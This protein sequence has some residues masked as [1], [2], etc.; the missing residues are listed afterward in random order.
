[1]EENMNGPNIT[2]AEA[3]RLLGVSERRVVALI[4]SGDLEAQKFGKSWAVSEESVRSRLAS[5]TVS[6]RPPYGQKRRDLIQAYT[7]MNKNDAVLHFVFDNESKRVVKVETDGHVIASPIGAC[8]GIGKPTAAQLTSWITD[9]YIPENRI[10]LREILAKTGCKDPAE[11]LF[12]TFGQNLTDQ[13]W[14]KPEGSDLDWNEINYF[15]NP[16]VGNVNEKGPGSGTPGM[17]PKWWEQRDGKNFLIKGSGQ[18]EREPFAELLA[19]KLYERLLEPQDFVTYSIEK[20][21]G[22]PHSVCENF[23]TEHTQ[24]VP[25][26]E[27]MSCFRRPQSEPY[28]YAEYIEVCNELGVT[29]IE[30]QL[31]KMIVCDFLTANID[32][33]DM[34]LGLIRDSETLQFV[35]VAPLFDNGRGFYYSAQ[36]E[37]DFGSRPFF[38]TSHPFSE[39]PS[40]QLALVRDYSWFDA[41]KLDGFEDEIVET[42][43]RNEILPAWFPRAAAKQFEIQLERVIEAQEEHDR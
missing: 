32:R 30:R 16:Y 27:V 43:S 36:R 1:M 9:R 19:S 12:Q 13:Y 25:L 31:A 14:F 6:G 5:G 10:G 42:L 39:Y 22:K 8:R 4:H 2:S 20:Y 35:G 7:L 34:N 24:L 41:R 38:H 28:N 37:S 26:R 40:S 11:L 15:H 21:E 3:A 33:H 23:I 18:G 17:L 29:D